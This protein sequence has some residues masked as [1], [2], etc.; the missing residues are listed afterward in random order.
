[1]TE[2]RL[3]RSS[4]KRRASGHPALR[5]WGGVALVTLVGFSVAFSFVEPAPPDSI[6]LATGGVGGAYDT[7]GQRYAEALSEYGIDVRLATTAGSVENV[8]L[9]LSGGAD[10]AFVQGGIASPSQ[11]E[12][13][14][15]IAS[16]YYEPL[17][18]FH[19]AD[20]EVA[21]L[22]D[23]V[24][25]RIQV[26]EQG[27]GTR[28]VALRLL[29]ANGL[30]DGQV[31][32]LE[33]STAEAVQQLLRGEIDAVFLVAG[34]HSEA[35]T[36]LMEAGEE[37]IRLL[38]M[39]RHL[40]YVRTF[41]YLAHVLL[42][43]GVLDLER[44][45]PEREL[46]LVAPTA[47]LLARQ[48]L[49]PALIPAFIEAGERIHGRGDLFAAPGVFP[50]PR[51][52]GAP[53]APAARLY[54]EKGPSFLYRVLPFQVAAAVDRL[55][56][57]LLPLLTLLFPL[58][59][60]APPVYRWRIRRKIYRWYGKLEVIERDCAASE[61][62]AAVRVALEQLAGVNREVLQ[63]VDVPASYKG[64]LY[65]LRMHIER[66]QKSLEVREAG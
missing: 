55:K 51:N 39:E 24:G 59:R 58:V 31:T 60:L 49:H 15:G 62:T 46:D 6:V 34:P 26:G 23:L 7:Y 17:W 50:S 9:L 11:A 30:T 61:D 5:L 35:V 45:V 52:L 2:S 40:A 38:E 44:N 36:T 66:L 41:P 56:I 20:L 29:Q 19:R 12:T 21:R 63:T 4:Q 13:L 64:E 1:M 32:L 10:V 8:E 54:F 57:L 43:E 27:S 47:T 18:I 33:L 37:R 53:L 16:L 42:A 14:K 28:I 25:R 48:D 65:N 22:T 3:A